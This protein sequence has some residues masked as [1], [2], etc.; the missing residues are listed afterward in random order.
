MTHKLTAAKVKARL[1][2]TAF[3]AVAVLM[4]CLTSAGIFGY[5]RQSLVPPAR[6]A[7]AGTPAAFAA[8]PV[9]E[10]QDLETED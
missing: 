6:T 2:M 7:S 10:H 5:V 4:V 3:V 8:A 9:P 1:A